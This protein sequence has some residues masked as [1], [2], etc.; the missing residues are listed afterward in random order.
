MGAT[1]AA[2]APCTFASSDVDAALLAGRVVASGGPF[3]EIAAKAASKSA[4]IGDLLP[5]SAGP[6]KAPVTV[7][8]RV[9][10]PDWLPLG[11]L[12]VY[13]GTQ[14]IADI[15]VS[16]TPLA[17]GARDFA[18]DLPGA[19]STADGGVVAMPVPGESAAPGPYR[20][21]WAV[22]NPV[23]LDWDGDGLWWGQVVPVAK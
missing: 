17:A 21:G 18:V 9:A 10:A 4:A 12:L 23:F 1:A 16:K 14:Q 15:D 13:S 8:V 11:H 22:T 5:L 7:H 19:A 3:L 6:G 20:P 2:T